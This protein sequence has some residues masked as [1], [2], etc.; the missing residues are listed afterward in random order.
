MLP[1]PLE[2]RPKTRNRLRQVLGQADTC[3]KGQSYSQFGKHILSFKEGALPMTITHREA[4]TQLHWFQADQEIL[5][6]LR[7]GALFDARASFQAFGER[8]FGGRFAAVACCCEL[9]GNGSPRWEAALELREQLKTGAPQIPL[10][11]S[12][13]TFFDLGDGSEAVLLELT[14]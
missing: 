12:T 14:A 3:P 1:Q 5:A 6:D 9:P 4:D 8:Q 2:P 11:Q 13:S 10:D 7:P